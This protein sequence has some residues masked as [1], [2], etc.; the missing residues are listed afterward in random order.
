MLSGIH[1][2]L[3]ADTRFNNLGHGQ[4]PILLRLNDSSLVLENCDF[5]DNNVE[6]GP[7]DEPFGIITYDGNATALIKLENTTFFTSNVGSR[8]LVGNNLTQW[9]TDGCLPESPCNSAVVA[10]TGEGSPTQALQNVPGDAEFLELE[11]PWLLQARNVRSHIL[12]SAAFLRSSF[13]CWGCLC[14]TREHMP[15]KEEQLFSTV[16]DGYLPVHLRVCQELLQVMV[17]DHSMQC[18]LPHLCLTPSCLTFSASE[19]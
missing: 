16:S 18:C 19:H 14:V 12:T 5:D 8:T 6:R 4:P 1:E 2:T 3:Y 10:G 17:P 9:F 13:H 11:D 7:D 15:W